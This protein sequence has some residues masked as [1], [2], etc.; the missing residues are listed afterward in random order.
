MRKRE[1]KLGGCSVDQDM[2][3]EELKFKPRNG[4]WAAEP[5][6][7]PISAASRARV[8]VQRRV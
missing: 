6:D 3:T 8:I 1:G 5:P 2:L 7:T 4:I